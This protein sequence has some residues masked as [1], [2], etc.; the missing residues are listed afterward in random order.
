MGDVEAGGRL[1]LV[2]DDDH[3]FQEIVAK[4]LARSGW[5]VDTADSA[6]AA[7]ARCL[8]QLPAV[9]LMDVQMPG[10]GGHQACTNMK[11]AALTAEVPIILMSGSWRDEHQLVRAFDCG[12]DDV[13]AKD[14]SP[15]EMLA[16]VR[17]VVAL[18]ETRRLTRAERALSERCE[19]LA[20]CAACKRVR[21]EG[22]HWED[23]DSY[24]RQVTRREITHGICPACRDRLYEVGPVTAANGGGGDK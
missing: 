16:R 5:G 18:A 10:L 19:F 22:N 9:I 7:F 8:E 3:D 6:E 14:H 15:M 11:A 20:V 17:S 12:A 4:H 1:V 24:L 23:V 21:A 2:V 13:L